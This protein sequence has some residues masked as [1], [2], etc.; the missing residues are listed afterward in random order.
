[1]LKTLHYLGVE[2]IFNGDIIL[3]EERCRIIPTIVHNLNI[4]KEEKLVNEHSETPEN[5]FHECD[6]GETKVIN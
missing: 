6:F 5:I 4:K 1:M 3:I 2:H